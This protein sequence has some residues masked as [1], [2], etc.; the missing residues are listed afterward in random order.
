M[1]FYSYLESYF[2]KTF[3]I[4]HSITYKVRSRRFL[5]ANSLSKTLYVHTPKSAGQSI[6]ATL[7]VVGPGHFSLKEQ[8]EY[9]NRNNSVELVVMSVRDPVD[10]MTSTFNYSRKTVHKKITSPLYFMNK[11]QSLEDFVCSPIFLICIKHHYFFKP[12]SIMGE[13]IFSLDKSIRVDFIRF[14]CID[15]DISRVCGLL[16]PRINVSPSTKDTNGRLWTDGTE[17]IVR[18]AYREDEDFLV[19]VN[20]YVNRI[21]DNAN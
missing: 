5:R 18:V 19:R 13:G 20:D 11:F 6:A 21:I 1:R 8:L 3:C 7:G 2:F 14:H 12:Q 9:L 4:F 10:R 16:P 17:K 15:R